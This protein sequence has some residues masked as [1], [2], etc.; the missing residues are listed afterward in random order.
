MEKKTNQKGYAILFT[1]VLV[2]IISLIAIGLSNTTYKQLVLSSGAKDSQTAF[3]ESDMATE[4]ALYADNGHGILKAD[5]IPPSFSCGID[6]NGA[7]YVLDIVSGT[8]SYTLEPRGMD[9][10]NEPCFRISIAKSILPDETTTTIEAS[11]YNL[12]NKN[13]TRT[14]ERTIEVSY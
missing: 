9:T 10:S 8:D 11:G 7:S 12:C 3:Y 2:S 6:K 1:V 14:V 5:P 4:C 13:A